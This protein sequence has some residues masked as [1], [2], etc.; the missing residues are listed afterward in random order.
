MIRIVPTLLL[1]GTMPVLAQETDGFPETDFVSVQIDGALNLRAGPTTDSERL[2]RLDNGTLL[3]RVECQPGAEED[4]CEVETLDG[5]LEGWAAVRFLSPHYGADPAA[6]E[7]P[8]V[9]A[10]ERFEFDAPTRFATSLEAGEI[11]DLLLTVPPERQI[12][13]AVQA[14]DGVG[15][16]VF[17]E[18]GELIGSG[19]GAV[20]FD[21]VLLSGNQ[22]LLRFAEMAGLG[23]DWSLDVVLD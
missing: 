16:A 15:T 2:T 17:D 10:S 14:D 13:I 5:S 9:A 20:A 11:F 3:R 12:T 21:V 1:A 23:G 8:T 19:Q 4:W 18:N 7:S 6:L 22:V